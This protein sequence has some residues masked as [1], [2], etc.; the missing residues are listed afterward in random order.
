M[1][2]GGSDADS[3][4]EIVRR[5]ACWHGRRQ[6]VLVTYEYHPLSNL[7]RNHRWHNLPLPSPSVRSASF[8]LLKEY[9]LQS[10]TYAPTSDDEDERLKAV[11]HTGCYDPLH[12]MPLH[13]KAGLPSNTLLD[14]H[15]RARLLQDLGMDTAEVVVRHDLANA[16]RAA[17]NMAFYDFA[18]GRRNSHPLDLARM[19]MARYEIEKNRPRKRFWARDYAE[20]RDRIGKVLRMCGRNFDRY[21]KVLL[22]PREIQDA[23]REV[24][25][26]KRLNLV[27]AARVAGLKSEQQQE[28]AAR[29]RAGENPKTVVA[30]YLTATNSR[31]QRATHGFNRFLKD[32]QRALADIEGRPDAIYRGAINKATPVLLRGRK[33]ITRLIA[34][35]KKPFSDLGALFQDL[36]DGA[37]ESDPD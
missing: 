15:R 2:P 33:L 37:E 27:S 17:V 12:I 4:R 31:H 26:R 24:D 8:S 19:V 35:G 36:K 9:P 32:L 13:N 22:C 30:T 28:I 16:E 1:S 23:V 29:I 21:Y 7:W 10:Q 14:G 5:T 3:R 6:A 34:E 11:L 18:L 20:T 25:R